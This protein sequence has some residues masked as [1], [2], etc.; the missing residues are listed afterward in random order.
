MDQR[1]IF[2]VLCLDLIRYISSLRMVK[3]L[4]RVFQLESVEEALMTAILYDN[5]DLSQL[6][7]NHKVYTDER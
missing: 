1:K 5:L 7:L 2:W 6:I 4:C 3:F